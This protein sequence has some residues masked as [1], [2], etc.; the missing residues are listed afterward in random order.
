MAYFMGRHCFSTVEYHVSQSRNLR[1]RQSS[2]RPPPSVSCSHIAPRQTPEASVCSMNGLAKSG[3]WSTGSCVMAFFRSVNAL[4]QSSVHL[5]LFGAEAL[6]RSV[7]MAALS[8]KR[9]INLLYHPTRLTK[10]RTFYLVVGTGFAWMTSTLPTCG[11]TTPC[12]ITW[13]RYWNCFV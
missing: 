2:G 11:F 12:P 7:R 8:V 4:L 5:T 6:V 10:A 1:L 9:G 13:P 3:L